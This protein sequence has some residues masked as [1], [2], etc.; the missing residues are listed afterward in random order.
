[1]NLNKSFDLSFTSDPT[2]IFPTQLLTTSKYKFELGGLLAYDIKAELKT[3]DFLIPTNSPFGLKRILIPAHYT[4]EL[5]DDPSLLTFNSKFECGNLAKA[6]KL[7]DYEYDLYTR[8]DTGNA[9][10]NHWYYFS[11]Q[12]PRKTSITFNICNLKKSDPL[13]MSGMKPCVWSCKAKESENQGWHRSG[14]CVSYFLKDN[15]TYT[16]KFTYGYKFSGDVVY[17]AYSQ[18]YSYSELQGYLRTIASQHKEILRLDQLCL[19]NDGKDC[20]LLTI[21][22]SVQDYIDYETEVKDMNDMVRCLR[23]FR[24]PKPGSRKKT[25]EKHSHKKAIVLMARVHSGET[26]SSFMML[27]AIEYLLSSYMTA[28]FLRKNFIFKII[29]MLNPDGVYFGNYRCCL[30]GTDL[31]RKWLRPNKISSPTIYHAKLMV[32]ALA[33]RHDIKLVCDFHGHTKKKSVFMYGCSVKPD[34]YEDMRNNLLTR[35][36]PYYMYKRNKFFSFRLSHYRIEKYKES[37]S[38][39]VLFKELQIPH[40]YTMEASFFGPEGGNSHFS[41]EDLQ[42]LGKD[43]CRFCTVFIKNSFYHRAI[44]DTNNYLRSLRV[45][46]L[47]QKYQDKNIKT[48]IEIPSAPIPEKNVEVYKKEPQDKKIE[49]CEKL[50]ASDEELEK[51]EEIEENEENDDENKKTEDNDDNDFW[52]QVD[53]VPCLPDADSSGS[54]SEVYNEFGDE[55]ERAEN[56]IVESVVMTPIVTSVDL[57]KKFKIVRNERFLNNRNSSVPRNEQ[58]LAVSWNKK[59]NESLILQNFRFPETEVEIRKTRHFEPVRA[60]IGV[61]TYRHRVSKSL[62]TGKNSLRFLPALNSFSK[63]GDN[64]KMPTLMSFQGMAEQISKIVSFGNS[65]QHRK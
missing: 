6:V 41:V 12:N 24:K 48:P 25:P 16:L 33:A 11:V 62:N 55:G 51:I 18:P 60:S 64:K 57:E 2:L 13:Y 22:D 19:S 47:M 4:L 50:Y 21:T 36:V 44:A 37:T 15:G 46:T 32:F 29:P 27:G 8:P 1:M 58:C 10:Q 23:K 34:N 14:T 35:V 54:D 65:L 17:F 28:L 56:N 43:L 5:P 40:C 38:R 49:A 59:V 61:R 7:S 9:E 45:K 31:N 42:T 20:S 52:E 63:S 26:V 53:I 30:K 3:G 39:I